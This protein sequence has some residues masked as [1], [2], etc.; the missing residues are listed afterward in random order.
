[1]NI[2]LFIDIMRWLDFLFS[3]IWVLKSTHQRI[4]F[5]EDAYTNWLKNIKK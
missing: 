2:L 3:L 5:G 4:V 1:M